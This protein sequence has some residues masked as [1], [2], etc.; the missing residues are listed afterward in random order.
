MGAFAFSG[1]L[2]KRTFG[3]TGNSS[4][5]PS[6]VPAMLDFESLTYPFAL[7]PLPYAYDALEPY[8]DARTMEIHYTKHHAGYVRK[9]N[10]AIENYPATHSL[11]LGEMLTD[12]NAVPAP[13]Q[14]AVRNN[15]GGHLNHCLF[16]Y[17]LVNPGV[18][19]SS[20]LQA[21]IDGAFGS[22][23]G[24]LD[25]MVS[26]GLGRFGSG[27]SWLCK[28]PEG[29]LV[30]VS[31]PNQDTPWMDDPS[32]RPLLGVDVWEHAYYLKYQNRRGDYLNAWKNIVDW[33][34]VDKR[35]RGA[36]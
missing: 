33:S 2:S 31:T 36:A 4:E 9:L 12:L 17:S 25:E 15:G 5:T 10:A 14:T 28:N 27:W 24:L 8:I 3:Q 11:T 34:A 23:D 7:P 13:I 1:L 32:L 26:T 18:T 20:P 30:V 29:G 35:L 19:P 22:V 16:W 21:T 6:G